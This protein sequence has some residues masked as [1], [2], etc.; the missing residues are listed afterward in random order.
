MST[1]L[2]VQVPGDFR[3][4]L[5]DPGC[6]IVLLPRPQPLSRATVARQLA[7]GGFVHDAQGTPDEIATAFAPLGA[8]LAADAQAMAVTLCGLMSCATVRA[9]VEGVVTDHCKRLHVDVVDLRLITAYA[10]DGTE[11]SRTGAPEPLERLPTGWIGLFKGA[12]FGEGHQPCRHRS[13]PIATAGG[14]R[15]LLVVDTPKQQLQD[16]ATGG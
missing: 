7:R 6:P 11:F 14:R 9:R 4:D 10:G 12:L 1:A 5:A 2:T 16:Q 8:D 13:P 3:T 15:L